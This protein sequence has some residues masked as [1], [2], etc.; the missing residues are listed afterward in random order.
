MNVKKSKYLYLFKIIFYW[1]NILIFKNTSSFF[2]FRNKKFFYDLTG[3]DI[4]KDLILLYVCF[5]KLYVKTK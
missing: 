5:I 4:F 2:E 1:L 3:G